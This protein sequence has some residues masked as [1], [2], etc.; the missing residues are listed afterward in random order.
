MNVQSPGSNIRGIVFDKDGTLFDYQKTWVVWCDSVLEDLS[1]GDAELKEQLAE[2][3]GFD[4]KARKFVVGSV[5]VNASA[6]EVNASWASVLPDMSLADVDKVAVKHLDKLPCFPVCDLHEVFGALRSKGYKLG[7][8]TNDYEEG[9]VVQLKDANIG[10]Y[11][12]FVCGF[13]SGHGSK[14]GPGMILGFC[15]ATGLQPDQVAMVG[16]STHDL[17]AGRAAKVGMN[18]GVLTGPALAEDLDALADVVL[19]DISGLPTALSG[20]S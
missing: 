14:P 2:V 10:S 8:A 1:G 11:F 3:C 5:I 16:D 7:I 12:D 18:V 20:V 9:A 6:E 17:H 4:L 15:E 19:P 13:D